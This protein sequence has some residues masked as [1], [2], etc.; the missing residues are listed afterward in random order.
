MNNRLSRRDLVAAAPALGLAAL[1]P[2]SAAKAA[3]GA[4]PS[5]AQLY[6]TDDAAKIIAVAREIVAEDWVGTFITV[7]EHGVPRARSVGVWDPDPDLT[8]WISTRRG[9]R[10]IDQVRSHPQATLHFAKDDTANNFQTAYYASFMGEA[11]VHIDDDVMAAHVPD[12]D[13]RKG[14]WPNF[15]RDYAVIRFR[16][17]WLE[18]YGRGIKGRPDTWQP[19]AVV[20]PA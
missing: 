3:P 18:V 13:I 4:A 1:L 14:Q 16:P 15:P 2:G 7:D 10:K 12:E 20:L 9:S 8:L 11:F 5:P 6:R 17:K 19:Q